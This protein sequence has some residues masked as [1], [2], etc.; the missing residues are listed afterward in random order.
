MT[1]VI[2]NTYLRL[3]VRLEFNGGLNLIM[4]S[5]TMCT[6]K[7]IFIVTFFFR[8]DTGKLFFVSFLF[9]FRIIHYR[10]S[11][12]R[13]RSTQSNLSKKIFPRFPKKSSRL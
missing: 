1:F 11:I 13:G 12:Y 10:I 3:T 7:I 2:I 4:K 8:S 5:P 9:L 6:C